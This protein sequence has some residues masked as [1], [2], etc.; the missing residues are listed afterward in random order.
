MGRNP[1]IDRDWQRPIRE[2]AVMTDYGVTLARVRWDLFA[3][4][5][6][7][8]PVPRNS[9][10]YGLAFRWLQEI[11]KSEHVPYKSLLSALR[12]ELGEKKGRPHFHCLVGGIHTANYRATAH[13]AEWHWKQAA[14]GAR[15]DV[16]RYDPTLAGAE[17]VA[18]CLGANAY[19]MNKFNFADEVT[20]SASVFRLIAGMDASGDRRCRED[21]C[22]NGS[23]LKAAGIT[24][25]IGPAV[26][27][28]CDETTFPGAGMVN[29][30]LA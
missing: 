28:L 4:L 2:S 23:V 12:G 10:A 8:G 9:I 1:R 29:G 24:G 26:S 25:Q 13:R 16:R 17:Y 19:E 14:R 27:T 22:K 15:V 21:R 18:Q 7:A 6:F 20:L 11:A 30:A 3:T 5:T